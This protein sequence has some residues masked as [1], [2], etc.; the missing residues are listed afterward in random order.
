MKLLA[1]IASV[2]LA[3]CAGSARADDVES[4]TEG[5]NALHAAL[6]N[7]NLVQRVSLT[8]GSSKETGEK[9]Y[10]ET[11]V[12]PL[13]D[14]TLKIT[15][16]ARMSQQMFAALKAKASC[17]GEAARTVNL[18]NPLGATLF[19]GEGC[20]AEPRRTR[21]AYRGGT[22]LHAAGLACDLTSITVNGQLG[23]RTFQYSKNADPATTA[24]FAAFRECWG[25][26][27][28]GSEDKSGDHDNILHLSAGARPA[29]CQQKCSFALK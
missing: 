10:G 13:N 22:S 24:F 18:A 25:E 27:S 21:S 19:F 6:G 28:I 2:L 12:V 17:V 29:S 14:G 23:D 1:A 26:N 5:M 4:L 7:S 20:F 3:F 16:Q 9:V 15:G 11:L 8:L